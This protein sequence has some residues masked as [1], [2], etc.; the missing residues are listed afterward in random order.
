MRICIL[1]LV[2]SLQS[3]GSIALA[4]G[5]LQIG[6]VG[7][8]ET[9]DPVFSLASENAYQVSTI[10]F[11][12]LVNFDDQDKLYYDMAEQPFDEWLNP[13]SN[14][15]ELTVRIRD[16]AKWSDGTRVSAHDVQY[17]ID[18][19]QNP[20][21]AT[22]SGK[23]NPWFRRLSH[24]LETRVLSESEIVL[25]FDKRVFDYRGYLKFG[26]LP[27]HIL[28][29][30]DE[31][32]PFLV[33][34]DPRL[35]SIAIGNG[36]Y[37]IACPGQNI[38]A[39]LFQMNRNLYYNC[40]IPKLASITF[41]MYPSAQAMVFD[42]RVGTSIQY[43]KEV[44]V[45]QISNLRS[46]DGLE[47]FKYT[48]HKFKALA[49][50]GCHGP[51]KDREARHAIALGI[52]RESIIEN[53]YAGQA[54]RIQGPYM[55]S[56]IYHKRMLPLIYYDPPAAEAI[57]DNLGLRDNDGDGWREYNGEEWSLLLI[58]YKNR[59]DDTRIGNVIVEN[60]KR[61]GLNVEARG[62]PDSDF[63]EALAVGGFDLAIWTPKQ[64]SGPDVSGF[65]HSDGYHNYGC[66]NNSEVNSLL[67]RILDTTKQEPRIELTQQLDQLI[68]DEFPMIFL[69]TREPSGCAI[70]N[71]RGYPESGF[72]LLD[73]TDEW[74]LE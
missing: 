57:L 5:K 13:V 38:N 27:K 74:Y 9:I 60:L 4:Q 73:K 47:V 62:L 1:I 20:N 12:G 63:E 11:R 69:F 8:I 66:Y 22:Q 25:V 10:M 64:S 44:P 34:G 49:L 42:L 26:L 31:I 19:L 48:E 39:V 14:E 67:S 52:N 56:S 68:A 72:N 6:L 30:D 54:S 35:R 3:I 23:P 58:F 45:D 32:D 16:C 43:V 33:E 46:L 51:F 50:N 65:Y 28:N 55:P 61:I 71:L 41:T 24:L 2:L 53:V 21:T 29:P 36:P 59:P 17:T 15:W 7:S 18:V 37:I 70:S 40:S